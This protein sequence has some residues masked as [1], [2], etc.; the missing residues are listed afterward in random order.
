MTRYVRMSTPSRS[1]S[2]RA[3]ALGRTLKPITSAFEADARLTSFS[4]IAADAGV[5]DVDAHLGML[6]LAELA[7]QRLDRSLHVALE[8]DVEILDDT[9]LQLREE[10]LERD[11]ALGALRELLAAKALGPLLGEIL[12]LALVLDD[13]CEL[14]GGRR[15]V[16]AED[17]D[18]LAGTRLLDL[19]AHVVVERAH[20][21]G[22]V[23]GDDRVADAQACRGGRASSRPGRGRRRG[24]T[25]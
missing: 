16:E 18:G 14:A 4:V 24:A 12:G 13:A 17:L 23:A 19:L 7:E 3:S 1:A 2:A 22:C 8:D 15:P 11:A 20:L 10:A 6:D 5:D 21:A 9:L 25:R